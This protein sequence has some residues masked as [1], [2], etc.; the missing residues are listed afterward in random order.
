M[1]KNGDMDTSVTSKDFSARDN[2][3]KDAFNCFE[4]KK[5]PSVEV[6][7]QVAIGNC[8]PRDL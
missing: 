6:Y 4:N 3:A 1:D 2:N 8:D 5:L 7:L